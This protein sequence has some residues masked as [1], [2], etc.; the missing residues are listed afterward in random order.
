MQINSLINTANF[1]G[2]DLLWKL[3]VDRNRPHIEEKIAD[4]RNRI[5]IAE[6][7]TWNGGFFRAQLLF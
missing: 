5:N 1:D 4:K 3:V 7:I 6:K 2:F